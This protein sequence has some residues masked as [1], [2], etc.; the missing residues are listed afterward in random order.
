MSKQL[1]LTG[2]ETKD[3][4]NCS[5]PIK[6]WMVINKLYGYCENCVEGFYF[7]DKEI[8]LARNLWKKNIWGD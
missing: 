4:P 5:K 2:A 3:C 6:V 8:C 1:T 7:K